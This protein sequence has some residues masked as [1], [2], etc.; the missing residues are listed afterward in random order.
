VEEEL[1]LVEPRTLALSQSASRFLERLPHQ[2]RPDVYESLLEAASGVRGRAEGAVT[3]L[4]E[5]RAAMR[6][7]GA[8]R[9]DHVLG[10]NRLYLIPDGAREGSYVRC[11]FEAM[12]AVVVQESLA[13]RC[14]VIG[15]DLGTVPADLRETLADWGVWSYRVMLFER[16]HDGSFRL[17]QHYAENALVSFSTHDLATFAGWLEDRDLREKRALGI[18]PGESDADRAAAKAGL[19]ASLMRWRGKERPRLTFLPI[20]RYL[21][22]TPSR[23]LVI[24]MEDALGL[25]DQPNVPGTV[26]ERPNWRHRLPIALEDLPQH[27]RMRALARVLRRANRSWRTLP[28]HNVRAPHKS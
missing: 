5:L 9:L 26:R 20:A 10:L 4:V 27:P 18:D 21:A 25:A 17:P 1:L 19:H 23:L 15:E 28:N 8:I 14:V 16:E 7:A 13:H 11:P 3:D 2:A 24:S 12:L 6:H 22:A